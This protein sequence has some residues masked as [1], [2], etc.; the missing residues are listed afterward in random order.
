[1]ERK[2]EEM[3]ARLLS[4]IQEFKRFV[5]QY[6]PHYNLD[7]LNAVP[8]YNCAFAITEVLKRCGDE[9]TRENLLKQATSLKELALPMLLNEI[10]V[11]NSPTNYAAFHAMELIQ[12]D[13]ER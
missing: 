3:L 13:G 10:K 6:M 8:G 5:S 4:D 12:F 2:R 1:L 7:D 9:L 11:S